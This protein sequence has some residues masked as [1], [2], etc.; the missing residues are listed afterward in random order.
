MRKTDRHRREQRQPKD[1]T[2][3]RRAAESPNAAPVR[4]QVP[5]IPRLTGQQQVWYA[6]IVLVAL[7]VRAAYLWG[8]YRNNPV[9]EHPRMDPLVHHEWAQQIASGAGMGDRPYLRAPLY[10]YLLGMLYQLTGPSVLAGRIAGCLLGSASCYLIARLGASLGGFRVGLVSGLIA[11]A[12]WPAVY[13]DAELLTVSLEVFLDV[14]LLL[15]LLSAG[16]RCSPGLFLAA[17]I[18]WGLSA[19]TRP[20]VLAFAPAIWCWAWISFP[21]PAGVLRRLRAVVLTGLG[22]AVV[23]LP[24]TLRNY[25]VGGEAVLIASSGGVNFFIGN[26]AESNGYLAEVPGVRPTW[27][28]WVEDIQTVAESRSGRSLNDGEV[29]DFWY[30]RSFEWIRS[31]PGA[32]VKHLVYKL[33]LF[34]SPVEIPNNQPIWF[35]ARLAEV[36][37]IFWVGFP[38]VSGLALGGVVLARGSSKAWFVPASFLLIYMVTVVAFFCPARFRLPVV[39]VLMVAAAS[40][41]CQ[42]PAWLRRRD[43][44]PLLTYAGL[45]AG[46]V[47]A[48]ALTPPDRAAFRA[49]AEAEGHQLFGMHFAAADGGADQ[50]RAVESFREAL[51]LDPQREHRR[52]LLA[53]ALLAN[54]E[55]QAAGEQF[56]RAVTEHPDYVPARVQYGVYL[57]GQ[58]QPTEAVEQYQAALAQQPRHAPTHQHLGRLLTDLNQTAAAEQHLREALA[59]RPDLIEARCNLGIVLLRRGQAAEAL[60]LLTRAVE[61][62][63]T[64]TAALQNLGAAQARLGMLEEAIGSFTRALQINPGLSEASQNLSRALR[65]VGRPA[66]AIQVLHRA[67]QTA[68]GD[69]RILSALSWMLATTP[70]DALRDGR[71]AVEFA[72]QAAA[73]AGRPYLEIMESLAAAY[74]EVGRYDEAIAMAAKAVEFA[75]AAGR[76][77]SAVRFESHLQHY[78]Q[79]RPYRD[80]SP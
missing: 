28:E 76:E 77:G 57:A 31:A 56:A 47:V 15:A 14:S 41:L 75:R 6:V 2:D 53:D 1:P 55:I 22:L 50:Q 23:V 19:I 7:A 67:R 60:P 80:V 40:G 10:Y 79:Q 58:A 49:R 71:Q 16:R 62:A 52:L 69:I 42:L 38:L 72:Q 3:V 30:G 9:F 34:W 12:Y 24:V 37:V 66:E 43:F 44:K 51:R 61:Q 33:G 45:C 39:P 73:I 5:S 11:A 65:K 4:D 54:N 21:K 18:L 29:S 26:N 64:N 25:L 13:F 48:L 70:D 27:N 35:L 46:S 32:W 78:E 59:I 8:Q 36:S 68:P 74:A 17:G 20:N 63:P